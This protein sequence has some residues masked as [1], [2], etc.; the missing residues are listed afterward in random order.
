MLFK[1]QNW[2]L[3][4]TKMY[5]SHSQDTFADAN[6]EAGLAVSGETLPFGYV[7][8]PGEPLIWGWRPLGFPLQQWPSFGAPLQRNCRS[9]VQ[10]FQELNEPR[11]LRVGDSFAFF[12]S[13]FLHINVEENGW[14]CG[15]CSNLPQNMS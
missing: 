15:L 2:L 4:G 7:S 8:K 11:E 9:S 13:A 6:A 1:K 14:Y 12:V 5:L 10:S 3:F